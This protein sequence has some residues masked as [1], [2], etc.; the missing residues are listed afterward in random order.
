M[1]VAG[2]GRRVLQA[3]EAGRQAWS[4]YAV[5]VSRPL[6]QASARR[7]G[8]QARPGG[9]RAVVKKKKAAPRR[10][11]LLFYRLGDEPMRLI[12]CHYLTILVVVTVP[13]L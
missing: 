1:G 3:R 8:R 11:C 7:G 9:K 6:C 2:E 12:M 5:T 13:S 10:G 4:V